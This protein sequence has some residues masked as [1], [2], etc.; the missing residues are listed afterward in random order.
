MQSE[1][2]ADEGIWGCKVVINHQRGRR[3]AL[4]A[5]MHLTCILRLVREERVSLFSLKFCSAGTFILQP[6]RAD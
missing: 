1:N 4:Q 2:V 3:Y 5:D 6:K